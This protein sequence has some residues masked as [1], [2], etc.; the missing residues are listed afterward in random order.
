MKTET[1]TTMNPKDSFADSYLLMCI[2]VPLSEGLV[3]M[4]L[5]LSWRIVATDISSHD[6]EGC[7]GPCRGVVGWQERT[8]PVAS[9]MILLSGR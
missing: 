6:N 1:E 3:G 9:L 4:W 5:P 7:R 2:V 8:R